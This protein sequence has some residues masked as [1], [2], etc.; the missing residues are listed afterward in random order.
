MMEYYRDIENCDSNKVIIKEV[1][2]QN[3]FG[4]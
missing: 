2:M 4:L 3:I 1:I